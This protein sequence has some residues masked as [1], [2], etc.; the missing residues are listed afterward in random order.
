M[1][2][3]AYRARDAVG[4]ELQGE[5]EAADRSEVATRLAEQGLFV[6]SVQETKPKKVTGLF[7]KPSSSHVVA[8]MRQLA[9]MVR[10]GIP[11]MTA[12]EMI[13]QRAPSQPMRRLIES[14]RD[15]LASGEPLSAAIEKNPDV[16]PPLVRW[17]VKVGEETGQLDAVL[18]RLAAYKELESNLKA[19]VRG[20]LAYPAVIVLVAIGVASFIVTVVIPKIKRIYDEAHILL[21]L[22]TRIVLFVSDF[23]KDW[24]PLL[25]AGAVGVVLAIALF[26]RTRSGCRFFDRLF[27]RIPI[28]GKFVY[29]AAL[30]RFTRSMELMVR[31]GVDVVQALNIAAGTIGNSVLEDGVR[32]ASFAVRDGAKISEAVEDAA[33]FEPLL[34]QMLRVGEETGTV[35]ELLDLLASDYENQISRMVQNLPRIIEPILLVFVAGLVFLLALSFFLPIFR[36]VQVLKKH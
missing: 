35:D 14:I 4:R 2:L 34:V 15:T 13:L 9:T 26:K 7:A 23:V 27:L 31:T 8:F 32:R 30:L 5:I 10:A 28:I 6:I 3:F 11:I 29:L 25:I 36:L 21:P 22:P 19:S 20:A 12:L 16:F 24:W 18:M 1:P 33:V 17:S